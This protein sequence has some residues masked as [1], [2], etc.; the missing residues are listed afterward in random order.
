MVH[1]F[2]AASKL[3][4]ASIDIQKSVA[5]TFLATAVKFHYVIPNP[6]FSGSP[7]T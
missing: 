2:Q 3:V 1:L 6:H 5:D 4:K 7:I